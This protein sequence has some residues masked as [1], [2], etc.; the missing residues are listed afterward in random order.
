MQAIGAITK[1]RRL[2]R[3]LK[4]ASPSVINSSERV[5]SSTPE[6]LAIGNA[7]EPSDTS[8]MR[9]RLHSAA[10]L[11]RH[12]HRNSSRIELNYQKDAPST[13]GMPHRLFSSEA[14]S[15]ENDPADAETVKGVYGKMLDYVAEKRTAP[16]N[17]L[18]WSLISK[19]STHEDIE[20]LFDVLQKHRTFRL[21]N[22]RIPEG[23]NS[24][25]CREV[26]KAC[27]RAGAIDFGKKT[28]W[29]HNLFG[30]TPDIGSAH[31]LLLHAKQHK[32]V[33][34]MTKIMKLVKINFLPLQPGTA[35]IV[36]SICYNADRWDL[37]SKNGKRFVKSG[38]KLR[39]TSFELWMEF[40]AKKGDVESLWKI[41]NWRSEAMKQH[42]LSTGFSCAKGFLLEHKP[43]G[44][45]AV[46]QVLY[47]DPKSSKVDFKSVEANSE[48]DF[49]SKKVISL[50]SF[51]LSPLRSSLQSGISVSEY[52]F[53]VQ[54]L[55]DARRSSIAAELQK[56][57]SEWPLDVI[58]HQKENR[59]AFA[60]TL[61][62]DIFT[63]INAL[64]TLGVDANVNMQEFPAKEA[65]LS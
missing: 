32:D 17:A 25:L 53:Y 56:L 4:N 20:L 8:S 15:T 65:F 37:M 30:L 41:E 7:C 45:A 36:F 62:K 11:S 5:N 29:K 39:P 44:A 54:T 55:S 61:Q 24:A 60:E 52:H 48:T 51:L 10:A 3:V 64:S 46:I 43:D 21:S 47:Q 13:M 58:K 22:L 9:R 49:D 31:Q 59:Q 6:V 63:L 26:T 38:V 57:V 33:N 50:L 18:L 14:K 27:I 34:L 35:D 12:P 23:F 42:S 19:C 40:A 2:V 16:P 1:S 28:L